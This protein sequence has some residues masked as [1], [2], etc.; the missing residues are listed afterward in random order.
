MAAYHS[1]ALSD[2]CPF[3]MQNTLT[4]P[5]ALP[6]SSLNVRSKPITLSIKSGAGAAE[7]HKV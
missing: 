4:L 7:A 6:K 1:L 5:K 2:L 3:H